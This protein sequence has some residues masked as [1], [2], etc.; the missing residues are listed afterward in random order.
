MFCP[1]DTESSVTTF[2]QLVERNPIQFSIAYKKEKCYASETFS[3]T[4]TV[5]HCVET[6]G[7]SHKFAQNLAN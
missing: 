7:S 1:D 4:E 5:C 2:V 3:V 6:I